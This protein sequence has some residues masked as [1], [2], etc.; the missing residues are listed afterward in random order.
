MYKIYIKSMCKFNYAYKSV[1]ILYWISS[2]LPIIL[3]SVERTQNY[4]T[5]FKEHRN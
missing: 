1:I 3:W 5:V 4:K 2:A